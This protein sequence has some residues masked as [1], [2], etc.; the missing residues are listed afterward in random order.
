VPKQAEKG[1][2]MFTYKIV[3]TIGLFTCI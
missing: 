2:Y 3:K 1:F